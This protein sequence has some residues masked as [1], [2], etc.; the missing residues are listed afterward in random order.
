MDDVAAAL[1]VATFDRTETRLAGDRRLRTRLHVVPS[2][3]VPD[4]ESCLFEGPGLCLVV[5]HGGWYRCFR[6][7]DV[8]AGRALAR[9]PDGLVVGIVP[10]GVGSVAL[11]AAGR[12]VSAPV[13]D[14]VYEAQLGVP[15]GTRL[16]VRIAR[17]EDCERE[18]APELL[19]R[20]ATLRRAA[21]GASGCRR[22]RSTCCTSGSGSSTRSSRTAPA[23][24]AAATASSSGP[25]R[26]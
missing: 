5:E 2:L 24:G 26:W 13:V 23:S 22:R 17:P 10:D 15:S 7:A 20:V 4:D 14:N 8:R 1:P 12:T 18:V 25:S 3:G 21:G 6:L 19:A 11:T 16:R 9:T